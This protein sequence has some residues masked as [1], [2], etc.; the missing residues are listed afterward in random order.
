VSRPKTPFTSAA[1]KAVPKLSFNDAITRACVI[2][3]RMPS[4]PPLDAFHASMESGK[5]TRRLK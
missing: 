3:S 1:T 2:V 4:Q 5:S